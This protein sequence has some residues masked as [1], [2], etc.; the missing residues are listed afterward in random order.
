MGKLASVIL[1]R[2]Q[3][4]QG[5]RVRGIGYFNNDAQLV[6]KQNMPIVSIYIAIPVPK[7]A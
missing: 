3:T 5:K 2:N 1:G 7:P 4:K 6:G